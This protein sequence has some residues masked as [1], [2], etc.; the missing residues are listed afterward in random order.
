MHGSISERDIQSSILLWLFPVLPVVPETLA[1]EKEYAPL[2][3]NDATQERY[4]RRIML[5]WWKMLPMAKN[6]Q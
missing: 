4:L 5:R 3:H 2:E 6:F 1:I